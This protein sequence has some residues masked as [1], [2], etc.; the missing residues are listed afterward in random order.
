MFR[1]NIYTKYS[2]PSKDSYDELYEIFRH[3]Q[4]FVTMK[5]VLFSKVFFVHIYTIISKFEIV[6]SIY[7]T[8]ITNKNENLKQ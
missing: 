7:Q 4:M 2:E 8:H 1:L 5:T 3:H 6:E